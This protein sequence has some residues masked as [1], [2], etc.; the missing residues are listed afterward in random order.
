MYYFLR[1]FAFSLKEDSKYRYIEFTD[2]LENNYKDL[3]QYYMAMS[4]PNPQQAL[5]DY[6]NSLLENL[7]LTC[8][9]NARFNI[10]K[11]ALLQRGKELLSLSLVFIIGAFIPYFINFFYHIKG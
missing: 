1:I 2:N 5:I 7:A 10:R 11:A 6:E 4:P 3:R 9:A 8:G